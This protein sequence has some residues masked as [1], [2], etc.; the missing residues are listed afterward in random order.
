MPVPGPTMM[1]GVG[2]IG[3]QAEMAGLDVRPDRPGRR[4]RDRARKP[5]AM[6]RR[7][8]PRRVVAHDATQRCTCPGVARGEEAMEYSRGRSG[9]SDAARSASCGRAEGNAIQQIE[10]IGVGRFGAVG[11]FGELGAASSAWRG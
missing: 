2:G 4:L 1:T 3:R 5:L 7:S 6:P 11:A 9:G 8:R 10:Q